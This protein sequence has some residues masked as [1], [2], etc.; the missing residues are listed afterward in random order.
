MSTRTTNYFNKGS[1]MNTQ[2]WGII[3]DTAMFVYAGKTVD[4]SRKTVDKCHNLGK[5]PLN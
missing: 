4:K 1:L 2:V 5:T 3:A